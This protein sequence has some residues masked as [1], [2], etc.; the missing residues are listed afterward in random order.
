MLDH[1]NNLENLLAGQSEA[2]LLENYADFLKTLGEH[3]PAI[4]AIN[5]AIE[6][7]RSD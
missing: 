6:L 1:L 2:M 7:N 5:V 4:K 3:T